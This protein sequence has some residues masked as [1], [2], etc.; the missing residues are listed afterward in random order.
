MTNFVGSRKE[1]LLLARYTDFANSLENS[2]I[3]IRL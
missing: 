3:L 2:Q 1:T